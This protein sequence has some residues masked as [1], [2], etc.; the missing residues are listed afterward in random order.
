[1]VSGKADYIRE[2]YID[3]VLANNRNRANNVSSEMS[4]SGIS[5]MIEEEES[6]RSS[7]GNFG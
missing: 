7:V 2:D 4:Y 5:S 1:M 6:K 3:T